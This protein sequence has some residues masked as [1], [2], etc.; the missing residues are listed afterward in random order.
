[1]K[2]AKGSTD[3]GGVR[4]PLLVR[5]PAKVKPGTIVTPIAAAIDLYPT[6]ID[7]AGIKRAGDKPF[8]GISLAPV[9]VGGGCQD[10]RSHPVQPL[11]WASQRP[12]PAIPPRCD[13]ATL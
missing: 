2:G 5:W 13:G 9:A 10:A 3:E 12:R 6:L 4:S 11:G 1:M 8:D 7:L